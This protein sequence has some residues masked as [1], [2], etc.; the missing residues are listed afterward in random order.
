V[1]DSDGVTAVVINRVCKQL[2]P[3]PVSRS[4]VPTRVFP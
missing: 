4:I 3:N 2:K 1:V